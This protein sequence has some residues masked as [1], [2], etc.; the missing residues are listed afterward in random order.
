VG[1]FLDIVG[2]DR[3]LFGINGPWVI[4]RPCIINGLLDIH[5]RTGAHLLVTND[6]HHLHV[7]EV[8]IRNLLVGV[9]T[10]GKFWVFKILAIYY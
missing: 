5:K 6:V 3:F 7:S 8:L 10:N 4:N 2:K 1:K 9:R